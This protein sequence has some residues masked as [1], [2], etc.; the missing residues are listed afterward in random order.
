MYILSLFLSFPEEEKIISTDF[1]VRM[2][3]WYIELI[4]FRLL[5]VLLKLDM[6]EKL[7]DLV[8]ATLSNEM[9][10]DISLKGTVRKSS[11]G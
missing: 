5:S 6:T 9:L 7:G 10:P 2:I 11:Y 1:P 4:H 3:F 8:K